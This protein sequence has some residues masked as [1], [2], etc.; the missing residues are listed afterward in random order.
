MAICKKWQI[1]GYNGQK[2]MSTKFNS[3]LEMIQ[4]ISES[5]SSIDIFQEK[6]Q[7]RRIISKLIAMRIKKNIGKEFIAAK[8]GC[9]VSRISKLEK[10]TDRDLSLEDIK[11]YFSVFNS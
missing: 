3:V 4:N 1:L 2:T 5:Q 7:S 6:I 9:K 11:S 8:I 10:G